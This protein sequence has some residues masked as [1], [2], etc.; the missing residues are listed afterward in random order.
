MIYYNKYIWEG[1][2]PV[3]K[4]CSACGRLKHLRANYDMLRSVAEIK[5]LR[6]SM[7]VDALDG[8]W[9]EVSGVHLL[10]SQLLWVFGLMSD[11]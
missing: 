5:L 7:V 10:N 4:G 9:G 2:L 6:R 3:E 8:R 1:S 11:V